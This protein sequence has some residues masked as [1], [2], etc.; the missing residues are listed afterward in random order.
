MMVGSSAVFIDCDETWRLLLVTMR[1]AIYLWDLFTKSCLLKDSLASLLS[2]QD[3]PKNSGETP[4]PPTQKKE[5]KTHTQ[6]TPQKKGAKK[7]TVT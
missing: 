1:G 4:P 7:K 3:W 6:N 2:T 5:E